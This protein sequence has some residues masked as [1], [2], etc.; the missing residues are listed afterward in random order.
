MIALVPKH[1]HA[2]IN[3]GI[4]YSTQKDPEQAI[5]DYE[6]AIALAPNNADAYY[7]WG[8]TQS[9]IKGKKQEA[10]ENYRKA[11]DLYKQQNK[12]KYSKN[13]LKKIEELNASK[14]P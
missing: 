8:F 12:L 6:K 4:A 10:I 3:R 13:A 7:A 11:A 9:L 14:S 5:K 1:I 2:Y